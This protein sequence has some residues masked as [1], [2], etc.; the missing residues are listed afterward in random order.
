[1][2]DVRLP[3]GQIAEINPVC[4]VCSKPMVALLHDAGACGD[5]QAGILHVTARCVT[6]GCRAKQL[7]DW[8]ARKNAGRCGILMRFKAVSTTGG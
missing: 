6:A 4:A 7:H 3:D 2:I 1:M 5:C 8:Q